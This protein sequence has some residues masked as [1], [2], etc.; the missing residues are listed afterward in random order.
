[1]IAST[2]RYSTDTVTAQR[3]AQHRAIVARMHVAAYCQDCWNG[4][5]RYSYE[6]CPEC[7]DW[8][9]I[10]SNGCRACYGSG[11]IEHVTPCHCGR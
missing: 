7:A 2:L 1:M 10:Y 9:L 6:P 3:A 5:V 11:L 8:E 4:G